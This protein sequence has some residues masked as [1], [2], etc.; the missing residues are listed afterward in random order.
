MTIFVFVDTTAKYPE[1]A[2]P[3]T[4]PYAPLSTGVELVNARAEYTLECSQT[5]HASVSDVSVQI[6]SAVLNLLG[7]IPL[8][9]SIDDVLTDFK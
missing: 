2:R 8:A 5:A 7:I 6:F 1:L 9:L 3:I 4:R